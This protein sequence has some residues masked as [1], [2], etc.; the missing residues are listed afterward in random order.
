MNG[1]G[2]FFII[3]FMS[4]LLLK[5]ASVILPGGKRDVSVLIGNGTIARIAAPDIDAEI[6]AGIGVAEIVDLSGCILYPGFIDIHIHGATGVDVMTA[7]LAALEKMAGFLA[8]H[9]ITRWMPTFVPDSAENYRNAAAVIDEFINWQKGKPVAQIA[10]LHYEGPFVSEK[11]CGALHEEFFR[12]FENKNE[13][14]SLPTLASDNAKRLMTMAPEVSGGIELIKELRSK[15]W[16][17]SIGHTRANMET[18]NSAFDA[19]ARHMTHFFNAMSGLHHRDVG[20]AGWGLT[21]KEMTCDVIADGIH[22]NPEILKLLVGIKTPQNISLI[23]DSV[24]PAGLGDG[25]YVCWNEKISVE[26]GRTANERGSIAGSVITMLDAVKMMLSL[27]ISESNA[28]QMASA[29]P[30]NILGIADI[31]GSIETGKNADLVAL[32]KNGNVKTVII[33]G[34]VINNLDLRCP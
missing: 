24:L 12:V 34:A 13:L 20:V 32:D 27:G 33:G 17:V 6:G 7:D 29:N 31:C 3:N 15:G 19:G 16:I 9:G 22:V 30:A 10:G 23:S 28:A 21:H 2:I 18:L 25:N 1:A 8:R 4:S 11:Q 5:N 26:N 14:S